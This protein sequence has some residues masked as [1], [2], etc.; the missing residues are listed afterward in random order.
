[1]PRFG[2]VAA[3]A[4]TIASELVE[5]LAFY[6]YLRQ[7]MGP[8]PW[9][10]VIG[11]IWL[12]GGLMAAATYGLWP[13]QPALALLAG[14]GLYGLCLV[15]LKAFSAEERAILADILP[16]RLRRRAIRAGIAPGRQP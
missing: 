13:V 9:A 6:W 3:A 8:V 11:V 7:S 16:E 12:G 4:I 2:F 10:S 14:F 5:C 1:M 15:G